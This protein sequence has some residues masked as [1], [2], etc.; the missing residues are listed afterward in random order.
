MQRESRDV[1]SK[2]KQ[3]HDEDNNDKVGDGTSEENVHI[4]G[5]RLTIG[6]DNVCSE[7]EEDRDSRRQH[8]WS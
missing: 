2:K 8:A 3:K 6:R 4:I 7:L 1:I 5:S